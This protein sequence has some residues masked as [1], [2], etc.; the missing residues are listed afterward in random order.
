M[1]RTKDE[2]SRRLIAK[3]WSARDVDYGWWQNKNTPEL[4]EH[5]ASL[6]RDA[7]HSA[8]SAC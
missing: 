1:T 3:G 7:K 8:C 5:Y 2:I 4:M 6:H